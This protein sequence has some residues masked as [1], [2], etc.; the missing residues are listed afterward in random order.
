M[1]DVVVQM[2]E[3]LELLEPCPKLGHLLLHASTDSVMKSRFLDFLAA[4]DR[5][6]FQ[7]YIRREIESQKDCDN[8]NNDV[9]PP[10]CALH[11]HLL[12]VN[13]TQVAVQIFASYCP[14]IEAD[15]SLMIG[16]MEEETNFPELPEVVS[17][18]RFHDHEHVFQHKS[19][20]ENGS[21]SD[22][23]H[24]SMTELFAVCNIKTKGMPI[25][26]CS[27]A[28]AS[29]CD[30]GQIWQGTKL[31]DIVSNPQKFTLWVQSCINTY[32]FDGAHLA[33]SSQTRFPVAGSTHLAMQCV[34]R[35]DDI[36]DIDDARNASVVRFIFEDLSVK[37]IKQRRS[38][39]N[40]Q[41]H[42][43]NWMVEL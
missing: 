31:L 19:D 2:D 26:S 11:V 9:L 7:D 28:F 43:Q 15:N 13:L 14:D 41:R 18:L 8:H 12:G 4:P 20:A 25:E 5:E 17:N 16:I 24:G 34:C 39:R 10:P 3:N 6:R 1:C 42:L 36:Q 27:I 33:G 40:M 21:V 38:P 32:G 22:C 35:F 29:L 30:R 37:P 23:S